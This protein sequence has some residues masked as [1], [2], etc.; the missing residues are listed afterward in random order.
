MIFDHGMPTPKVTMGLDISSLP[1]WPAFR[2]SFKGDLVLPGDREYPHAI[3]R[4]AATAER[5]AGVVAF[6][7]EEVDVST[8]LLS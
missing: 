6:V 3:N 7:K 5:N 4:W 8:Y 1:S 2:E